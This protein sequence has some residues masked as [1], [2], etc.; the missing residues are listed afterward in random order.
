MV[1]LAVGD[2]ALVVRCGEGE[3]RR[4]APCELEQRGP[5]IA[6]IAQLRMGGTGR[7]CSSFHRGTA[8]GT[9]CTAVA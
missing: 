4:L 8:I 3:E 1:E 7:R 5:Q 9:G 6:R 2:A